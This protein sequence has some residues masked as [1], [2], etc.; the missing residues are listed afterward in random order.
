MHE[1]N[2]P[3]TAT[4]P[5]INWDEIDAYYILPGLNKNFGQFQ[6]AVWLHDARISVKIKKHIKIS[7][8]VNNFTNVSYQARPG[9]LR[10]PTQY[11]GQVALKF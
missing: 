8:I 10:A 5:G 4:S 3:A 9:D 11:V 6:K 7:F 1:Y 2:E